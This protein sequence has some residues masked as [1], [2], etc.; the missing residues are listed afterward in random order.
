MPQT[1]GPGAR[2][3]TVKQP[4]DCSRSTPRPVSRGLPCLT[5]GICAVMTVR[6]VINEQSMET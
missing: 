6:S 3:V 4:L 2:I 1:N 5:P